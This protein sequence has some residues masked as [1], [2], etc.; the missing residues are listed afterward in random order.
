MSFYNSLKSLERLLTH[1]VNQLPTASTNEFSRQEIPTIHTHTN[2][3]TAVQTHDKIDCLEESSCLQSQNATMHSSIPMTLPPKASK[4]EYKMYYSNMLESLKKDVIQ[5]IS[6]K[7]NISTQLEHDFYKLLEQEMNT[8]TLI[9]ETTNAI[10]QAQKNGS[11]TRI[12]N[13]LK[14]M[15]EESL[16]KIQFELSQI[17]KSILDS[18]HNHWKNLD[19]EWWETTLLKCA[20]LSNANMDQFASYSAL[21]AHQ[22]NQVHSLLEN[23]KF[24]QHVFESDGPKQNN[25]TSALQIYNQILQSSSRARDGVEP[26]DRLA[27]AVALEHA[28]PIY[29]FDTKQVIDPLKRYHH[30]ESAYLNGELDENFATLST[31]EMRMVVNNDAND[32]EIAWCRRMLRNYR[33]DHILD[34]NDQW[35][36]CMIVKSDVRYKRPEWLPNEPKSY[37][38]MLSNGGMCGPRAWFGRFVCKSFGV[39]TWGVRQPSHAAM[40]HKLPNGDWVICLGGPNWKKSYWEDQNGI[41]FDI[42]TKARKHTRAY[43][44]VIFIKSLGEI[45]NEPRIGSQNRNYNTRNVRQRF[46]T[47]LML[48]QK[49]LLSLNVAPKIAVSKNSLSVQKLAA[50][51]LFST[52]KP[53]HSPCMAMKDNHMIIPSEACI[54][55]R[56]GNG[57][58][59]FMPSF[60]EENSRHIHLRNDAAVKYQIHIPK[61]GIYSIAMN[62]VT[63]HTDCKP[64]TILANQINK[65]V[66]IPYT[67]GEWCLTKP[68]FVHL[69]HGYNEL[70]VTSQGEG[71]IT[72]KDFVINTKA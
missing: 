61:D 2:A 37:K 7:Q 55:P 65:E 69:S 50:R 54:S 31:W 71:R 16:N 6:P 53:K 10:E 29:I 30:Y 26:F 49:K 40:S 72:I 60:D 41:D 20:L 28:A 8:L 11:S 27:L 9:Q 39:P 67:A 12:E 70:E 47:E 24:I 13:D 38:V 66:L 48:Q 46:W 56:C 1:V 25:Y 52:Q 4:L 63:V 58:V 21:G 51:S 35:K 23:P 33:P 17:T 68:V 45:Y 18:I 5:I 44:D 3:A 32:Y 59:I 14:E 34:Q 15:Q 62:I 22:A 19:S 43:K 64:L 42:D 36:Y 57:R